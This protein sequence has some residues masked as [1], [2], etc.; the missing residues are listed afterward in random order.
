MNLV[1]VTSAILADMNLIDREGLRLQWTRQVL[2]DPDAPVERAS[3]DAS[4][5]SYW[6]T[7]SAGRAWI[8]MDAPPDKED[9][10][11]WLDVAGRLARAGLHV[12]DIQAADPQRGFVL[13]EDLGDR[14]LLPELNGTHVDG[15]Y[16]DA[17]RA[18]LAM[19]LNADTT[20][21]PD[22]DEARLVAEMEL[23]PEWFLKRHLGFTPGCEQWDIIESAFR[24]LV[25]SARAQP[26]VFVHRDF[27]SRNLLVTENDSPGV[28]DFQD[29]VRGPITYDLVSLLRD[30]Y[31]EWPNHRVEDW[32]GAYR[33]ELAA[34]GVPVPDRKAFLRAFDLMGLQRHIKVLGI[35]CRLWYRDGKAG[36]LQDLPLVWKYTRDV[37]SRHPETAPLVALIESAIGNHDITQ[38]A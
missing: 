12:P 7:R 3:N 33:E 15:L 8:V 18:L 28:I 14:I 19:Q 27:H 11:P 29:A 35:F 37:G 22:Y 9:I 34:A 25:S 16:G 6:R 31:I 10:Q 13:M 26:Q 17:M 30:C 1:R 4:F 5:R 32:A 21:L 20:G 38:P 2:G 36:Y 24:A 23:M